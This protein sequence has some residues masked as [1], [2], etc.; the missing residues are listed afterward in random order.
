MS[1]VVGVSVSELGSFVSFAFT[2]SYSLYSMNPIQLKTTREFIQDRVTAIS[3]N[4]DG[5]FT[6]VSLDSLLHSDSR[7]QVSLWNNFYSD[8]E[9]NLKFTEPVLAVALRQCV[10]I[11]I[12]PTSA[13][14]Y[15][16]T[17]MEVSFEQVTAS[18]PS[19]CGDLS[20]DEKKPKIAVCGLLPGAVQVCSMNADVRPVF[21]Q[22]HLHPLTFLRFSPNG[23]LLATASEQGTL[24]RVFDSATGA[25]IG[26]FRR[27][28]LRSEVIALA[29]SPGNQKL[30]AVS[31]KGTMHAFRLS[32]RVTVDE[33][34][35]RAVSKVN[36][37]GVEKVDLVFTSETELIVVSSIGVWEVVK[38]EAGVM[39]RRQKQL[40][41][42]C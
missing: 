26:V 30:V 19:G 35:P 18:N 34:A 15:D 3:T 32:D 8:S 6:A 22:A 9:V 17:R 10:L 31:R 33:R 13:C 21:F 24:I 11:V 41:F 28:A 14:L 27:G 29:I 23:A 25:L 40:L 39:V 7:F 38:F 16:L 20:F 12:L 42:A 2:H 4:A 5:V 1:D 36:I 37:G